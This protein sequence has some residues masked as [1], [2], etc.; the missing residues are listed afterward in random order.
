MWCCHMPKLGWSCRRYAC[1]LGFM[2]MVLLF[3]SDCLLSYRLLCFLIVLLWC[4]SLHWIFFLPAYVVAWW[5][6]FAPILYFVCW[7]LY[8][9]MFELAF[10]CPYSFVLSHCCQH[11]L[12]CV[13]VPPQRPKTPG[14]V[15]DSFVLCFSQ[16]CHVLSD[17]SVLGY[18]SLPFF[19][20]C[21]VVHG[22]VL[23]ALVLHYMFV[24][25]Y[26]WMCLSFPPFI[27]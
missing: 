1:S 15:L 7:N 5:F 25:I 18:M 13:C 3:F 4:L 21:T 20:V 14:S 27:S 26:F 9:S 2:C 19:R 11:F 23:C 10:R 22:S 6:S 16:I 8:R 12:D 24:H 17:Y